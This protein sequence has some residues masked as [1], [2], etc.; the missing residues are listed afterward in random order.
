MLLRP[1]KCYSFK[2]IYLFLCLKVIFDTLGSFWLKNSS[3]FGKVQFCPELS[4]FSWFYPIL[5]TGE[6]FSTI[7]RLFYKP[8]PTCLIWWSLGWNFWGDRQL[9][10]FQNLTSF[11]LLFSNPLRF[12]APQRRYFHYFGILLLN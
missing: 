3:D 11:H 1:K 4:N 2:N 10:P 12:Y 8:C 5:A 6:D 9:I 7:V